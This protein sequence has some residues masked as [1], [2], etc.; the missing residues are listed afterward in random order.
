MSPILVP[1]GPGLLR[2][3]RHGPGLPAVRDGSKLGL[4]CEVL[5]DWKGSAPCHSPK[6]LCPSRQPS[7]S[8]ASVVMPCHN[9]CQP[10][11]PSPLR[12][13]WLPGWR[14]RPAARATA[15]CTRRRSPKSAAWKCCCAQVRGSSRWKRVAVHAAMMHR[16][17]G[18][19]CVNSHADRSAKTIPPNHRFSTLRICPFPVDEF[20]P[21]APGSSRTHPGRPGES[22]TTSRL[23]PRRSPPPGCR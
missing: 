15:H 16:A 3:A 22:G 9:V 20:V 1:G 2:S 6:R 14:A 23:K 18:R 17:P 10:G 13:M 4:P 8:V 12:F 21:M 19:R 7:T 11:R 5:P